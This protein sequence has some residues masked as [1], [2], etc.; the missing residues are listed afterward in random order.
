MKQ[1]LLALFLLPLV[2][3]KANTYYFSSVSGSDGRSSKQAQSANT[4]W[5][6][7]DKL[8]SFFNQ[9]SP[10][11]VVLFK[12]GETF[13]GS[14][15]LIE[16]G[17]MQARS[18]PIKFG[19]YGGTAK[20][21]ITGLRPVTGWTAIGNGIYEKQD[22]SFPDTLLNLVLVNGQLQPIGRWPKAGT[23]N[24]G[25]L[26]F[27]SHK[28]TSSITSDAITNAKSFVGGEVV[29][30]KVQW[31]LDRGTVT[32]QTSNTVSYS[33][34]VS[35]DHPTVTYEPIDNYGF[36]FQNHVNTLTANGDWCYDKTVKKITMFSAAAPPSNVTVP[37]FA[38]LVNMA[39]QDNIIFD[40]IAF[41]GS[42]INTINIRACSN[43]QVTNCDID[44]SGVNGINIYYDFSGN[45]VKGNGSIKPKSTLLVSLGTC[46]NI[47]VTNCNINNTVNN[48]INGGNATNWAIQNNQINNTALI[49]GM[50]VSGDGQY[51]AIE[52]VN[53]NSL[54]EKNKITN[55]GYLG[56]H[57]LGDNTIVRNNYVDN[58]CLVK[59]DGGGIYTFGQSG[60]NRKVTG[61]IVTNGIGDL[62]G[63][64]ANLNNPYAG[65]VHGIYM[66][67]LSS[68]VLIDN[69]TCFNNAAT[70]LFLGS[71]AN[72]LATKN[73]F[74]NNKVA[75]VKAID[76]RDS[77]RNVDIKDNVLVATEKGQ[78]V[79]SYNLTWGGTHGNYKFGDVDYNYYCRPLYEPDNYVGQGYPNATTSTPFK[80]YPG[81]GVVEAS[82][83]VWGT[84]LFY[85][86][87]KWKTSL[88]QL[89][90]NTKKSPFTI[91]DLSQLIFKLNADGLPR[92]YTLDGSYVDM[93]GLPYIGVVTLPPFS[94]IVL[95]KQPAQ[96]LPATYA[97]T[98]AIN[99]IQ[100]NTSVAAGIA[101][102]PNPSRLSTAI[103][104]TS[105]ASGMASVDVIDLQGRPVRRVFN[106]MMEAGVPKTFVVNLQ[107]LAR[108]SYIIRMAGKNK[109]LTKQITVVK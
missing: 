34:F 65:Q 73:V 100:D 38:Y 109:V 91:D 8:N 75:Q 4:P 17:K 40:N 13:Y 50:G 52:Y 60:K 74:Y 28:D 15:S 33:R 86:L 70:G 27:Q 24:N 47:K 48:A 59:S 1:I 105:A 62:Y 101:A 66:D 16:K 104:I 92:T 96:T 56:I 83:G 77:I 95:M 41:K 7:I 32:D 76:S 98:A 6:S 85:S 80:D 44:C 99:N 30:R 35:P 14:L 18:I 108:G 36:F 64:D 10:G 58:F 88:Q 90:K 39:Y 49:A 68:D 23:A 57:F 55:T 61:N 87:D 3:V 72:I 19:S 82:D 79:A 97:T 45:A 42:N 67:A 51:S 37:D 78:L 102:F 29:I 46:S 93:K 103:R 106:G 43:I 21:V 89:D 26:T 9:L 53:A 69:N 11:D 25:Y 54:I 2:L 12:S 71:N 107:G 31:I 20:P 63:T 81:G 84:T 22:N 94:S 5:K